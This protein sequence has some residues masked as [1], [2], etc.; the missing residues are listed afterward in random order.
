M[1]LQEPQSLINQT[2]KVLRVF[3]LY[4]D[5]NILNGLWSFV[6]LVICLVFSLLGGIG[7]RLVI[8]ATAEFSTQSN[9]MALQRTQR[10]EQTFLPI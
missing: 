1:H 6:F 3:F 5:L 7:C 8:S 2:F 9:Y 10:P 4:M